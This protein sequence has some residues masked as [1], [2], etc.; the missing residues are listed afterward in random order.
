MNRE[1]TARFFPLPPG[2][3]EADPRRLALALDLPHGE[4]WGWALAQAVLAAEELATRLSEGAPAGLVRLV[5]EELAE[6][7]DL[8]NRLREAHPLP[9]LGTRPATEAEWAALKVLEAGDAGDL[10]GVYRRYGRAPFVCR[11]AFVWNRELT[12]VARPAPAS[13]DE[14]VGYEDAIRQLRRLVERF[15]K[16]RPVPP[17]LLYGARGTGKSTAVRALVSAYGEQGLRL[18]EVM[19][20]GLERLPLLYQKLWGLPQRFVLFL[21]DLAFDADDQ[22]YRL[23]KSLLEGA[24]FA[25]PANTMILATGNRRNLVRETWADREGPAAFDQREETLSFADRFG[26]VITFPPFDKRRYLQ[27]VE[28]H[29]GR[30]LDPETEARAVK[31]ALEGRGF[32]GRAARQFALLA[33]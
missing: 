3:A 32:S 24:L 19:P 12:P 26:V 22:R 14:L 10:A 29:L 21:D 17:V 28:R 5:E 33:G 13:F 20:D 11:S 7:R 30:P 16:G 31:F 6:L 23:L 8:R 15:L 25:R 1:V 9:D 2:V 4:P 18:I 27:A